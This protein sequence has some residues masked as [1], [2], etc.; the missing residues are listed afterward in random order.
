[1]ERDKQVFEDELNLSA[2]LGQKSEGGLGWETE[3][4]LHLNLESLKH[5][6][7]EMESCNKLPSYGAPVAS[8]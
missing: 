3:S 6:V 1:M 5:R 2:S 8:H 4:T 7:R